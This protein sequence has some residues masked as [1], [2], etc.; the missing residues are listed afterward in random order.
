MTDPT[1]EEI[2]NLNAEELVKDIFRGW[3]FIRK[4]YTKEI[5]KFQFSDQSKT[6][7]TQLAKKMYEKY[8]DRQDSS[9]SR[10][11]LDEGVLKDFFSVQMYGNELYPL[12]TYPY[13]ILKADSLNT[14]IFRCILQHLPAKY[15]DIDLFAQ[16]YW[17]ENRNCMA[18]I[19]EVDVRLLNKIFS[20]IETKSSLGFPDVRDLWHPNMDFSKS[21]ARVHYRRLLNL[22]I[23]Q[24]RSL[25]NYARLGL[26]PL[27]KIYNKT[28]KLSQEE[29]EFCSWESTLSSN[30]YLRILNI[31]ERSS[32]WYK[33]S[34]QDVH[35]LQFRYDG[36]NFNLFN[37]NFWN[38][39]F[40]EQLV[41]DSLIN[42]Q[43]PAS[44]WQMVFS[45]NSRFPFRSSDLRLLVELHTPERQIKHL[46]SR[47]NIHSKY[48][49]NRLKELQDGKLFQTS[50]MLHNVGLNERYYL[51]V[52]GSED[53]LLPFYQFACRLPRYYI[54]KAE[55][56]IYALIWL[57]SELQS[58]FLNAC[59]LL[60]TKLNL[61]RIYYGLI[62]QNSRSILPDLPS[63]WNE[64]KKIWF[65]EPE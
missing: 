28:E 33:H 36:I 42:K 44:Q 48:V 41:D 15:V 23:L 7:L 13:N 26:I 61:Q 9:Q 31:P 35:I 21:T 19:T 63:L 18:R 20:G 14:D 60:K 58:R 50:F 32:F 27:L 12:F 1:L 47:A 22:T 46:G 24:R 54:A 5:Q 10:V 52:I 29:I 8:A 25:I 38:I 53:E 43:I 51:L 11:V 65:T 55:K 49:S 6:K 64:K 30:Q 45:S 39:D 59:S 56:C 34:S 2:N 16:I 4:I 62:D 40:L 57:P 17:Q 37:G 3:V